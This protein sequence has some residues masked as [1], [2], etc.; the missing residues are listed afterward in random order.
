MDR[1][2]FATA[3]V[4]ESWNPP[5]VTRDPVARP[6]AALDEHALRVILA[7]VN[8]E[9]AWAPVDPLGEALHHLRMSGIF[10][11]RSEF[12]A[13]WG[14]ELPRMPHSLLFH[15]VTAGRCWLEIKGAERRLLQAGDFAL[16]PHGEG[17]RLLSAPGVRPAKLFDLPR[18]V[19]GERYELIR[20]HGGGEPTSMVCGAVRFRHPVAQHLVSL[21]PKLL[22]I[23]SWHVR[24][25]GWIQGALD[26][27]AAEVRQLRPGGEAIITR[28]ADILVIQAV[29]WWL[30]QDPGAQK[31]WL[32]ALQDRQVG[33]AV[34]LVHRE[35][36]K[37][38]TLESL[39]DAA[40]MSR[41]GFAARFH[42]LVGETPMHYVARW[43]MQLARAYL[44]EDRDVT[45]AELA[46]RLGYQSEAAFSRAFKRFT[47][48]AP[49]SV[50]RDDLMEGAQSG[51]ARR[52]V[53][54]RD[55]A[56]R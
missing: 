44:E 43:R 30:E 2:F 29:R 19:L 47:G 11:S 18:E 48:V 7:T 46:D 17:H 16:V 4:C 51:R 12:T 53:R 40:G 49:G 55:T 8:Y 20:Q 31:G 9:D 1:D 39:A 22:T 26:L 6:R 28:L 54:D 10:Y 14:L 23:A 52:R 45:V 37:T 24:E 38:W 42:E 56:R 35:P 15:V 3:V 32:A 50:R 33:R 27:M 36:G 5:A 41:S 34:A 25:A 21:L 13:P